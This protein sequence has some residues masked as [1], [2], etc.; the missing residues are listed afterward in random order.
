MMDFRPLHYVMVLL[1]DMFIEPCDMLLQVPMRT[2]RYEDT[3]SALQK[4]HTHSS[5]TGSCH[6]C[7]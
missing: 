4:H 2:R 6:E 3:A 7:C 1:F 5:D